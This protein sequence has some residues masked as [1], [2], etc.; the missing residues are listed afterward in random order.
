MDLHKNIPLPMHFDF[1]GKTRIFSLVV[2]VIMI[3]YSL[4][5]IT[6]QITSHS[7]MYRKILPFIILFLALETL[8]KNLLSIKRITLTAKT[9]EF[10]YLVQKKIIIAWE[11]LLSIEKYHGRGRYFLIKYQKNGETQK[12]FL[13]M[14]YKDIISIL[15]FI[16]LLAPH[17]ATDEF[18]SSLIIDLDG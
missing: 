18:I 15:N 5:Y 7:A 1:A 8:L 3:A 9:L 12:F 14:L 6:T 4:Y 2:S 11:T 16:K 10:S 13:P 17:I